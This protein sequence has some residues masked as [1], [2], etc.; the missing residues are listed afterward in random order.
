MAALE[1]TLVSMKCV[2]QKHGHGC[3]RQLGVEREGE[4]CYYLRSDHN[5]LREAHDGPQRFFYP[6]L[7]CVC[8]CR[9]V[10]LGVCVCV[11]VCFVCIHVVVCVCVCVCAVFVMSSC[12]LFVFVYVCVFCVCFCTC[13]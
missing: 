1:E 8:V 2:H 6:L 9:C 10:C 5:K 12:V 13:L 4:P 7:L 11:F 3:V